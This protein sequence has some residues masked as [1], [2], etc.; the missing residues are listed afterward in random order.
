LKG[1]TFTVEHTIGGA[2]KVFRCLSALYGWAIRRN[3]ITTKPWKLK[4]EKVQ[5]EPRNIVW[6]EQVRPFLA[7]VDATTHTPNTALSIR[8]QVALG[9]RESETSSADWQWLSWRTAHYTPGKTKNRKIRQ[10]PIP[11]W[12]LELLQAHWEGLG[13]PTRGHILK[14]GDAGDT[15]YRG[16]TKNAIRIAGEAL[17][18]EGLHP[19]RLRATFATAHFESGTSL[20][21]IM[22]MLGH[23][24]PQTTMRYIETRQKDAIEAQSR[25]AEAMGF[26]PPLKSL[27]NSKSSSHLGTPPKTKHE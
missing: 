26:P 12:L 4:E 5:Q 6:P 23:E 8:L 24:K 22:L 20:S 15:V 16:F 19:H 7:A 10:I 27:P 9:L 11:V 14:Y 1:S 18:I 25:V 17:G 13:K 2:N 21:Q 3:Y